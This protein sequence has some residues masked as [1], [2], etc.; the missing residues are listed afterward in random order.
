MID[1]NRVVGTH[2]ILLVTLDT[3]R[4]DVACRC[5]AEGRTPNLARV[6]PGGTWEARRAGR[7]VHST[8]TR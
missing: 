8:A 3:L 6:L 2:D 4:Y 7:K 1:A 5:L